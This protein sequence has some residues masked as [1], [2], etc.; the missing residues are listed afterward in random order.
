MKYVVK[1]C[2]GFKVIFQTENGI[3]NTKMIPTGR[4][5]HVYCNYIV[6]YQKAPFWG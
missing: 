1:I 2:H 6:G 5:L 3:L 4:N